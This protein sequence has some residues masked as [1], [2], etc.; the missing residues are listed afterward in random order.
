MPQ[1]AGIAVTGWLAGV[2]VTAATAATVGTITAAAVTGAIYGAVIGAAGAVM[3]GGDIFQGALKG[4]AIGG[5]TGGIL[6]GA[7]I[8]IGLSPVDAVYTNA[9]GG[10]QAG[11]PSIA[12]SGGQ[13]GVPF[14]EEVGVGSME[15]Y[16]SPVQNQPAPG[17]LSGGAPTPP[18]VAEAASSSRD[19]ILA[20]VTKGAG[21]GLGLVGYGLLNTDADKEVAEFQAQQE[22]QVR[23]QNVPGQ[24]ESKIANITPPNWWDKHLNPNVAA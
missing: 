13:A 4:A 18:P 22:A 14:A 16:T 1:A 8:A 11:A 15:P 9:A 19:S 12:V 3:T 24:F 21:E 5:I 23:S 20:S 17:I 10:T 2:G 6:K 7:G